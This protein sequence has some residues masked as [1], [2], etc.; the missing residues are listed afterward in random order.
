MH[1]SKF[2]NCNYLN[3][4]T[5][6]CEVF[7]SPLFKNSTNKIPSL[8]QK[9]LGHDFTRRSL[10]LGFILSRLHI[11]HQ[12]PVLYV[13]FS[14]TVIIVCEKKQAALLSYRSSYNGAIAPSCMTLD[15]HS[16]V[17]TEEKRDDFR[18]DR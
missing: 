10:R 4:S 14:V 7:V 5:Y 16:Y 3:V 9:P 17:A 12:V 15:S 6:R 8:S 2:Q 18:K 13:R 11:I 1:I